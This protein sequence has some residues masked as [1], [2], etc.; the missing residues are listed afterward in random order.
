MEQFLNHRYLKA[1][2]AKFQ[3][4]C[5]VKWLDVPFLF[6]LCRA[7]LLLAR[8]FVRVPRFVRPILSIGLQANCFYFE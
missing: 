3:F 1:Y 2:I 5:S 4:C 6:K 8:A 7:I